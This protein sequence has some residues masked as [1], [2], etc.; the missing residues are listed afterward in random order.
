M[1]GLLPYILFISAYYI[2]LTKANNAYHA[3]L[4]LMFTVMLIIMFFML[5]YINSWLKNDRNKK[6]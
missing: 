1:I 6:S 4:S 3:K 5:K 2:M